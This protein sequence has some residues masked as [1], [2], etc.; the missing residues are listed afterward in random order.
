MRTIFSRFFLTAAVTCTFALCSCD[1]EKE[2]VATMYSGFMT[3]Y[4]D[5]EGYISVLNDDF[6]RQYMVNE[7][8][9]QLEPDTIY[10]LV[11]SIALDEKQTARILQTAPTMSYKAIKEYLL[12]DSMRGRDPLEIQGIYIGGGYLNINAGVKVQKEGTMHSLVYTYRNSPGKLK[13]KIYHNAYGDGQIYSKR[14]YISIPLQGYGLAKN[15]TVFL[16]CKGYEEDYEYKLVY[17]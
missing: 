5:I 16:S 15:D 7:K 9:D 3:G 11:A 8:S 12:P 2:P 14:V 17:K 1:D 10:R 13:F 4:T 6:G